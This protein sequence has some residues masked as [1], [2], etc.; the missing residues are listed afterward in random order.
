MSIIRRIN[1]LAKLLPAEMLVTRLNYYGVN[2]GNVNIA[3]NPSHA[4]LAHILLFDNY[5]ILFRIYYP[6][7]WLNVHSTAD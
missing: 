5:G 4:M 6:G 7:E 1:I 3:I 2:D